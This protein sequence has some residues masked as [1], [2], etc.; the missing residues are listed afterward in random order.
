M[1]TTGPIICKEINTH[2][3]R[4]LQDMPTGPPTQARKEETINKVM[5]CEVGG[6][7]KKQHCD[8]Y[9]RFFYYFLLP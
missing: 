2:T 4:A 7:D 5:Y 9:K 6:L 8:S 3:L 1:A